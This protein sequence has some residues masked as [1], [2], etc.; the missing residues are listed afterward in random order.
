MTRGIVV[1]AHNSRDIDYALMAVIAAGLAKKNLSLPVSLITD[2]T[3]ESW[4]KESGTYLKASAV[5][6]QIILADKPTRGNER[7]LHDGT[8]AK[9]VPFFNKNRASV[10]E[11]TPYDE[12]LLID[13]DFLI[14]SDR[15]NNYWG[16]LESVMIGSSIKDIAGN[17]TRYHDIYVSDTGVRLLWATTVMFRKS[18]DSQLF[19]DTV[20]SVSLNYKQISDIFRFTSRVYRNDIAFGVAKHILDGFQT[21]SDRDLP[22]IFSTYDKDILHEVKQDG[23]LLFLIDK[24]LDGNYCLVSSSGV[25]IHIMNKQSIVRNAEKLLELI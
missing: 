8:S 7:I 9:T 19:F 14:F 13:S 5:F 12:T 10:Y 17:R 21:D 4:M 22:P 18:P 1:F 25:D 23:R 24:N 15:L 11:L 16:S 20:K 6:D 2:S 3:T